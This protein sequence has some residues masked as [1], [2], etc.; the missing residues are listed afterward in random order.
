MR[1]LHE[2]M[3]GDTASAREQPALSSSPHPSPWEAFPNS[4]ISTSFCEQL[5][6]GECIRGW[7]S[8]MLG[9][10]CPPPGQLG[11]SVGRS[12]VP[13]SLRNTALK[14]YLMFPCKWISGQPYVVFAALCLGLKWCSGEAL[15]L[16]FLLYLS[17]MSLSLR[18]FL[19]WPRT[20]GSYRTSQIMHRAPPS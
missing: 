1:P 7:L 19:G 12:K 8:A 15:L 17:D 20:A 14:R 16:V 9:L 11:L 18:H 10:C 2:A 13:S 3:P 5:E 4:C 6:A